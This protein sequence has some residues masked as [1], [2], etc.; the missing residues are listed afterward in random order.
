M[1]AANSQTIAVTGQFI[2]NNLGM[3]RQLALNDRGI[4]ITA[5]NMA[6]VDVS[7][8]KLIRVLPDWSPPTIQVYAL[9]TT[10]LLPTKVRVFIDFLIGQLANPTNHLHKKK[11]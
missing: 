7:E 5:E 2:A 10:R 1:S 6:Q 11:T 4:M 9:T 3:L 8:G